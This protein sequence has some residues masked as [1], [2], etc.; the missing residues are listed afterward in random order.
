MAIRV[1]KSYNFRDKDPVIDEL[2]GFV[3]KSR[4]SYE[5]IS[6]DSG[7]SI[8]TL[9]SWFHGTVRRPQTTTV[10]AVGRA[11]GVRRKWVQ[12]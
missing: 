10:E 8:S 7:V 9:T 1:Y 4:K 6:N 11:L 12:M 2:R 5:E 3:K